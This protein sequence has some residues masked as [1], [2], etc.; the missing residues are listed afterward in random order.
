VRFVADQLQSYGSLYC[1]GAARESARRRLAPKIA[2]LRALEVEFGFGP[3]TELRQSSEE[4]LAAFVAG[5]IESL[6]SVEPAA[7]KHR[8]RVIV[9]GLLGPIPLIASAIA[10]VYDVQ[11]PPQLFAISGAFAAISIYSLLDSKFDRNLQAMKDLVPLL[12][13]D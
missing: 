11:V 10:Y 4:L 8:R 9:A 7:P 1:D 12:R 3:L 6:P 13:R 2:A 5:D